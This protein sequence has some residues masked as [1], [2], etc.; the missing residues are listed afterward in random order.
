MPQ[1]S[2][3]TFNISQEGFAAAVVRTRIVCLFLVFVVGMIAGYLCRGKVSSI[4]VKICL[5]LLCQKKRQRIN[6][7]LMKI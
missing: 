4:H 3:T 5:L 1:T 2:L 7:L 6:M